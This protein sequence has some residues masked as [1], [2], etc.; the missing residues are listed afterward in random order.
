MR[1]VTCGPKIAGHIYRLV[2][3]GEMGHILIHKRSLLV[4]AIIATLLCGVSVDGQ[5]SPNSVGNI[6][7][8]A[9]FN[10]MERDGT[11]VYG[12]ILKA[13][14]TSFTVQP[15]DKPSVTLQKEALL[16][17]SQGNALLIL[18]EVR[19]LTSLLLLRSFT[20]RRHLC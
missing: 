1:A 11:C 9:G 18:R 14:I 17:V 6:T 4:C 7:H 5:T 8:S 16:Q 10:F 2:P 15:F 20:L 19:G 13:D 12:K 3:K